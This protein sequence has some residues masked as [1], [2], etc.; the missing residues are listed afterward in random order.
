MGATVPVTVM[1]NIWKKAAELLTTDW[2]MEWNGSQLHCLVQED[3]TFTK[4]D[5]IDS[6]T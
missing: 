5:Q 1:K 3:Q 6:H 4:S 2:A